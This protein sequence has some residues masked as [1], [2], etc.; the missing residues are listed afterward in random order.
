MATA[1]TRIS[2]KTPTL[3][4][5]SQ[6]LQLYSAQ[7]I[8]VPTEF[9][10]QVNAV[11]TILHGDTSGLVNSLLDFA[12]ESAC[13]DFS[14]ETSNATLTDKLNAWLANVN[15][16]LRGKIP[17]GIDA[18]AK[19]Y[20]RE[21]WK[22]SSFIVLRTVWEDVD[23]LKLPTKMWFCNGRDVEI[24][25]DEETRAKTL[26]SE[27]YKLIV[28]KDKRLSIPTS[29][30][31]KIFIQ[32]PFEK[33]SADYP[34][35]YLIKRG[36]YYNLKFLEML[37]EKGANLVN[38]ALEYLMLLKKGDVELAKLGK[39]EFTYDEEDLKKIKK[40]F[41]TSMDERNVTPGIPAYI[42]NFDTSI[43][44]LIPDYQKALASELY[45]P[46]ERRILA[47]LGFIEVLEGITSSRKD[48]VLN[49]K[50]FVSEVKAGLNDFATLITDVLMT[51][52][53][54]NKDNHR[55]YANVEMIQIRTSPL[56][57]FFG[58]DILQFLRSM[59]DRGLI[60]KRTIVEL[61]VDIDFDAEVERRK[62][63]QAD[64]I[65]QKY[66]ATMFPPIV[67]NI[68]E[69]MGKNIAKPNKPTDNTP[70]KKK[71][72]EAKNFKNMSREVDVDVFLFKQDAIARSK[73]LKSSGFHIF[74][75]QGRAFYKPCK[76]EEIYLEKLK[77]FEEAAVQEQKLSK[78]KLEVL[79]KQEKVLDKMNKKSGDK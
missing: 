20:F 6:L 72:P 50:V 12:I 7:S 8:S 24:F 53:E 14:V 26:G 60:S 52:I 19:E 49:P 47:G 64:G 44:H 69:Q 39:P 76:T 41:Q 4:W 79:D 25:D 35:P 48:S 33:W 61:G 63:E 28:S 67:N 78:K 22:S 23:G 17:V 55:K 43:E 46:I 16:S 31:E 21:R 73:E 70:E 66:D 2:A 71:G 45:S 29:K 10:D 58:D 68:D 77:A 74:E 36:V 37:N 27:E 56:K 75:D 9:R 3:A 38:K 5:L 13:V 62:R 30:Q 42:S 40:D 65:D 54:L 18:L 32:K 15:S 59:Y 34:T 57:N 1:K 11:D 51:A